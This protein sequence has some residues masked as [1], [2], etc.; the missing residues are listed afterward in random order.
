[1]DEKD[2][3]KETMINFVLEVMDNHFEDTKEPFNVSA[4]ANY[5]DTDLEYFDKIMNE[6]CWHQ[7]SRHGLEYKYDNKKMIVTI[8]FY[9]D[10]YNN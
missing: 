4:M 8:T 10:F 7:T 6:A 3:K 2:F 5:E 1:M 9:E